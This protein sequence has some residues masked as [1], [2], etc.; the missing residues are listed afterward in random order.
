M[1]TV[2]ELDLDTLAVFLVAAIAGRA[3][4]VVLTAAVGER[5][6]AYA[7]DLLIGPRQEEEQEGRDAVHLLRLVAGGHELGLEEAEAEDAGDFLP[8]GGEVLRESDLPCVSAGFGHTPRGFH[9]EEDIVAGV[10]EVE[11]DVEVVRAAE[12]VED[13]GDGVRALG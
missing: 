12:G 2:G 13:G 7:Y 1:V 5:E 3:V 8:V 6:G 4:E 11:A 9:T 10:G